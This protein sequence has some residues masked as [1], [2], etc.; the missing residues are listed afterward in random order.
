VTTRPFVGAGFSRLGVVALWLAFAVA[1]G[2]AQ[3]AG[4]R[5]VRRIEVDAGGGLIGGA[6]LGSTDANLT[7]NKPTR[8]PFR[9]FAVASRLGPAPTFHVRAGFAFTRR[10]A[11]EGGLVLSHPEIEVSLSQDVEGAAPLTVTE[12]ID[13][14]FFQG[15]LLVLVDELRMGRTVPFVA[16]GAGYLRQLHE[17]RTFIEQGH[18][19]HAGGGIKHWLLARSRGPIRAAGLRGDVRLYALARGISFD[20]GPR[21]HVAISGSVFLGF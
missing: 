8:Q 6:Q 3:P 13:Q 10:F 18:V 4:D 1:P 19:Y 5:P 21:S 15:S 17:G 16:A 11:V 7:A 9:L 2:F 14:Y 20:E 12:R